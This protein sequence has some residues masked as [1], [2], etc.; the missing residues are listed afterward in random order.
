[1]L[2]VTEFEVELMDHTTNCNT[3]TQIN[4]LVDVF[5]RSSA[6]RKLTS[7]KRDVSQGF[8]P[9]E[10]L[11]A[12]ENYNVEPGGKVRP[13][14]NDLRRE[15]VMAEE[16]LVRKTDESTF[17]R[18]KL[19][20]IQGVV[21]WTIQDLLSVQLF[22]RLPWLAG[23]AGIGLYTV[24]VLVSTLIAFLTTLSTSAIATNG[25]IGSKHFHFDIIRS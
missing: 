24:V 4:G 23:Q 6:P 7:L 9:N 3:L 20:W 17:V 19:G 12:V 22:L 10:P 25:E 21:L 13:T 1:M 14:L 18:V 11:P 2:Q 5:P 8:G 15:Q 16:E